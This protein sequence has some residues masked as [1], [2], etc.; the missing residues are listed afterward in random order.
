MSLILDALKKSENDRQH[1]GTV[2]LPELSSPT[3]IPKRHWWLRILGVL[4]AVNVVALGVMWWP[5]DTNRVMR[6]GTPEPPELEQRS[7]QTSFAERVRTARAAHEPRP[8][9][10][11]AAPNMRIGEK[12][13]DPNEADTDAA[14]RPATVMPRPASE[15]ARSDPE[16]GL[17]RATPVL[18]APARTANP[19]VEAARGSRREASHARRS[20]SA[21]PSTSSP[22]AP[23]L[24]AR[25]PEA[26]EPVA[27]AATAPSGNERVP[28]AA[29]APMV[30]KER[31]REPITVAA[32][33]TEFPESPSHESQTRTKISRKKP[34]GLPVL[35]LDIHVYANVPAERF[36]FINMQKLREGSRLNA[37]PLVR[38]ITSDGVVLEHNGAVFQLPRK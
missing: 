13:S 18:A 9:V 21:L 27:G 36:V 8:S 11:A 32:S 35:H 1:H 2:E 19:P 22:P 14:D 38:E 7:A 4:L 20:N 3:R 33:A 24:E 5:A 29:A 12:K 31:P 10:Q 34:A 30:E 23:P 6:Q 15:S 16:A 17:V 28:P 25:N 37:G 26:Q